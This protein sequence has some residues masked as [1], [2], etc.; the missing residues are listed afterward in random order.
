MDPDKK[1][2]GLWQEFARLKNKRKLARS[3]NFDGRMIMKR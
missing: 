3:A 2:P 1:K